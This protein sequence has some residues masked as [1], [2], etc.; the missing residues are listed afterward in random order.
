MNLEEFPDDV[1]EDIEDQILKITTRHPLR[2]T[3]I[4]AMF[5]LPLLEIKQILV[6]MSQDGKL[7]RVEHNKQIFWLNAKSKVKTKK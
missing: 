4:L 5:D 3:Q 2:E 7:K 1:K 6:K